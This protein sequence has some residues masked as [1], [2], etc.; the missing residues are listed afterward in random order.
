[1]SLLSWFGLVRASSCRWIRLAVIHVQKFNYRRRRTHR[2]GW[3]A[4]LP[5]L[6]PPLLLLQPPTQSTEDQRSATALSPSGARMPKSLGLDKSTV[7]PFSFFKT[8]AA[9]ERKKLLSLLP[10]LDCA[11]CLVISKTLPII[12]HM[13]CCS[14]FPLSLCL[15]INVMLCC[16]CVWCVCAVWHSPAHTLTRQKL[17][18]HRWIIAMHRH[19]RAY[20]SNWYSYVSSHTHTQQIHFTLSLT[21][22]FRSYIYIY[23]W[24]SCIIYNVIKGCLH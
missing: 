17:P 9:A 16:V 23:I 14:F 18:V 1:M 3:W 12:S 5:L 21:L 13:A 4:M 22:L 11:V 20:R 15:L 2:H 19:T 7:K 24:G 10:P 8:R 6:Q